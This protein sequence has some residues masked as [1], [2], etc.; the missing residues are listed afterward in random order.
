MPNLSKYIRYK[1]RQMIK[2]GL[3]IDEISKLTGLSIEQ[4]NKCK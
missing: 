2:E 4:V 3:S 1:V